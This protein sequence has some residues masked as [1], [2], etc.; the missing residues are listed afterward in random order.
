MA[1][2]FWTAT[3]RT[4]P[5]WL[6]AKAFGA[7]DFLSPDGS[8]FVIAVSSVYNEFSSCRSR[9]PVSGSDLVTPFQSASIPKPAVDQHVARVPTSRRL[10]QWAPTTRT[11]PAGRHAGE[12]WATW[13][14]MARACPIADRRLHS[15]AAPVPLWIPIACRPTCSTSEFVGFVQYLPDRGQ[16]TDAHRRCLSCERPDA[17]SRPAAT[18]RRRAADRPRPAPANAAR[19][20]GGTRSPHGRWHPMWT[21]SRV[22]RP[23]A[24]LRSG[25]AR[26]KQL[27]RLTPPKPRENQC[28]S[29]RRRCS[30]GSPRDSQ[31]RG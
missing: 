7:G 1:S 18:S 25:I 19:A 20:N 2:R 10:G 24:V 23:Q 29:S 21:R 11:S 9:E 27:A 8:R 4:L 31:T 16:A 17:G 3:P 28:R 13:V 14:R 15:Q 26:C 5:S 30:R 22:R 12:N 6:G